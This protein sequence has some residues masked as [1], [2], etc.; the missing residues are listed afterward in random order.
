MPD[1]IK[2]ATE[3]RAEDEFYLVETDS[4]PNVVELKRA[5]KGCIDELFFEL[6]LRVLRFLLVER[7]VEAF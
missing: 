2:T 1:R 6:E 5:M 4:V 3:R 7:V